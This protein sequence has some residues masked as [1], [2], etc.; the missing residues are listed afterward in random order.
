MASA[1]VALAVPDDAIADA[2]IIVVAAAFGSLWQL[3][4][5]Y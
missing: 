2:L 3:L 5:L 1:V 4:L